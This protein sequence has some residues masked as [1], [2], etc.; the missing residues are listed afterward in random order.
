LRAELAR[1]VDVAQSFGPQV[2]LTDVDAVCETVREWV[3]DFVTRA[4]AETASGG[5]NGEGPIRLP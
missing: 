2:V 1:T 5:P 3:N 4:E